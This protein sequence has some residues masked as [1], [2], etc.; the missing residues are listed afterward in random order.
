[1]EQRETGHTAIRRFAGTGEKA[2][3]EYK[4]WRKWSRAYLVTQRARGVPDAAFGSLLY[5][6]LDLSLIHISEPTRR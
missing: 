3:E 2:A 1:M 6:L 4:K 5:T